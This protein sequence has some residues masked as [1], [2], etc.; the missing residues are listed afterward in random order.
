MDMQTFVVAFAA[1]VVGLLFSRLVKHH[2]GWLIISGLCAVVGTFC[3]AYLI[4]H[5]NGI[6]D[7]YDVAQ[8]LV[9]EIAR[10]PGEKSHAAY[11]LTGELPGTISR[12]ADIT[13]WPFLVS[14]LMMVYGYIASAF[15]G[16]AHLKRI[17]RAAE[18]GARPED[19]TVN[20]E[21]K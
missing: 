19:I 9:S 6:E 15:L 21:F 7:A 3:L 16:H 5:Y 11:E 4:G 12:K 18:I 14:F 1:L 20:Y 17:E 2:Y 13:G 8:A 10:T